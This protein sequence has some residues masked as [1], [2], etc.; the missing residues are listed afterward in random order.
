MHPTPLLIAHRGASAYRP[1]HTLAAYALAIAQGADFIEPDFVATADGELIA[2][3]E[4]ALA[5][6]H[7]DHSLDTTS[8]STDVHTRP[9]FAARLTTKSVDGVTVRGWFSEDFTLAEIKTLRATERIPA[10]RP[11]N[12]AYNGE[13]AIPTLA[14]IVALV[15]A[16]AA[17]TGRPIGLYP[18][19][20]H[21]TYFAREG[22]R[23]TGEPIGIDLGLTLVQALQALD[24]TDPAQ[25]FIQSFEPTYLQV[26]ATQRLPAAGYKVP[27]IQLIEG[28]GAPRDWAA[29]GDCRTYADLLT[30]QGLAYTAGY[31]AGVGVPKDL[32]ITA[33]GE[34]TP[35]VAAAHAAGLAVYVWTFR[36]EN[37]FLPAAYRQGNS[38]AMDGD[39]A[40]E[41]AQHLGVGID[42]FFIDSP[43]VGQRVRL[44]A[45]A[46]RSSP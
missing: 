3:H 10:L 7:E 20:K 18:E 40:G 28:H 32:V 34:V 33:R 25:I 30:P 14:E 21:P 2:R 35:L 1:D 17:H 36:P 13:F 4:N 19:T 23:L 26:L 22:R 39:L 46:A 42:G 12:C 6:L 45:A 29:A 5:I 15:R 43:D 24:F 27:L 9:E 44:A 16:S 11:G 38:P 31:A 8:S 41:L 37:Y